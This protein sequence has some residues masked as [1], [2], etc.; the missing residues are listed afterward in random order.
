MDAVAIALESNGRDNPYP[1]VYLRRAGS[2][3]E[4]LLP[5]DMLLGFETEDNERQL[6]ELL[7][8][9]LSLSGSAA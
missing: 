7:D 3:T 6:R 1:A 4:A 5:P 9:V 8:P 2:I